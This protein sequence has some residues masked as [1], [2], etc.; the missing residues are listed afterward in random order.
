[1]LFA[2]EKI[3]IQHLNYGFYTHAHHYISQTLANR[4]IMDWIPYTTSTFH[5]REFFLSHHCE[6]SGLTI[7]QNTEKTSVLLNPS[8]R[9]YQ[10]SDLGK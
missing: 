8:S 3:Q 4:T 7:T 1:M 9:T 10:L 6:S 5:E 2:K